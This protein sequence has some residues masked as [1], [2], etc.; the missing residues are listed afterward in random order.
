[1]KLQH[2][3]FAL[4]L[5]AAG[6]GSYPAQTHAMTATDIEDI[7]VKVHNLSEAI[8]QYAQSPAGQVLGWNDNRSTTTPVAAVFP[9]CRLKTDRLSYKV[10]DSV[11]ITWSSEGTGDGGLMFTDP[12]Y[13]GQ[14]LPG[15]PS[16]GV[17]KSSNVSVTAPSIGA[18]T[19]TMKATSVTKQT[20]YCFQTI[21]VVDASST[22]KDAHSSALQAVISQKTNEMY[23]ISANIDELTAR[24]DKLTQ[25]IAALND[26]IAKIQQS[27]STKMLERKVEH[28][29][30]TDSMLR[31][32]EN[33]GK[34]ASSTSSL[35]IRK[36]DDALKQKSA[37]STTN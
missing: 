5:V 10:G 32:P 9:N 36:T 22:K 27:T 12:Q 15:L 21:S 34:N 4:A 11:K 14:N 16:G 17:E 2:T 1:M 26:Q 35:I 8:N 24:L 19:I 25:E 31:A 7:T 6:I 20:R 3:A 18:Y 23:R 30:S 37:T 13:K 29:T 28:A 33:R